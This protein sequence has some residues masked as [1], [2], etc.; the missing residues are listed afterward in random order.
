MKHWLY[1]KGYKIDNWI[2][3]EVIFYHKDSILRDWD[4][5]KKEQ[6]EHDYP[7][8]IKY[9]EPDYRKYDNED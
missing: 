2:H 1:N 4:K 9:L 5:G 7:Q 8:L 3:S 6:K